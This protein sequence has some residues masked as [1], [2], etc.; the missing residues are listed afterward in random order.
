MAG[1]FGGLYV[2]NQSRSSKFKTGPGSGGESSRRGASP[3]EVIAGPDRRT[4]RV[5]RSD[6]QAGDGSKYPDSE[7]CGNV[8]EIRSEP[9]MPG[10]TRTVP[11]LPAYRLM[12]PPWVRCIA[13][14]GAFG[15]RCESVIS[16]RMLKHSTPAAHSQKKTATRIRSISRHLP[17][18]FLVWRSGL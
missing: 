11:A 13:C 4:S 12:S 7:Y 6:R 10:R 16:A 5:D 18:H 17:V 1:R 8:V 2:N 14:S 15:C 3:A 9:R